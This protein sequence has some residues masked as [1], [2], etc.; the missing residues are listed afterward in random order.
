MLEE[1]KLK[2]NEDKEKKAAADTTSREEAK[3]TTNAPTADA[4]E[5]EVRGENEKNQEKRGMKDNVTH[6]NINDHMR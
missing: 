3:R 6:S 2:I 4:S 5:K 1:E